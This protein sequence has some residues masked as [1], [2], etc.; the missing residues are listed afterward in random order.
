MNMKVVFVLLIWNFL[1][2]MT[3]LQKMTLSN[4]LVRLNRNGTRVIDIN[5]NSESLYGQKGDLTYF[6]VNIIVREDHNTERYKLIVDFATTHLML[7]L[8]DKCDSDSYLNYNPRKYTQFTKLQWDQSKCLDWDKF[9]D[10]WNFTPFYKDRNIYRGFYVTNQLTFEDGQNS[11]SIQLTFGTV[12]VESSLSSKQAEIGVFGLAISNSDT[13]F[14]SIIQQLKEQGLINSTQFMIWFGMQNG[15]LTLGGYDESLL[16]GSNNQLQW[17]NIIEPNSY[18]IELNQIYI[19]NVHIPKTQ[20]VG[21]FDSGATYTFVSE[22]E[23]DHITKAF[24]QFCSASNSNCIGKRTK[25]LCFE[26]DHKSKETLSAF[27][28]S[29]PTLSFE[30]SGPTFL[31][32][33]PREYFYYNINLLA[34]WVGIKSFTRKNEIKFGSMFMKQKMLVFDSETKKIGYQI[35]NCWNDPFRVIPESAL[36]KDNIN[37]V[38][39][40]KWESY[41]AS[42][43]KSINIFDILII[44]LVIAIIITCK[45]VI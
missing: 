23:F 41:L 29:F 14:P 1:Y 10:I 5:L 42:I 38:E 16:F 36:S 22:E 40:Y 3:S 32:W 12:L 18:T 44:V 27:Y 45:L 26:F 13:K 31:I 9:P 7:P 35:A 11:N 43:T 2:S 28:K 4:S 17:I 20:R 39:W 25:D 15:K 33:Y 6:Y 34:F 24:L 30:A 19:G 37:S 21:I 8:V